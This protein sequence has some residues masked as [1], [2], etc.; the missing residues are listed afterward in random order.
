MTTYDSDLTDAAWATLQVVWPARSLRGNRPRW[1]R[2]LV[3]DAILEVLRGA[4]AWRALPKEVPPWRAVLSHVRLMRLSDVWERINAALRGQ[5][6]VRIGRTAEPQAAIIDR[7]S[8][9]TTNGGGARGVD[10]NT[11]IKGRNRH[12][13]VDPL[14]RLVEAVKA[15]FPT[16]NTIWADQGAAGRGFQHL[17]QCGT[18]A[19][20]GGDGS[21][22]AA[23]TFRAR[24]AQGPGVR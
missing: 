22:A 20:S 6:R 11:K 8:A 19:G 1:P 14:G 16:R 5:Y 12:S 3:I 9:N 10:G 18:P 2:R 13:L 15:N 17:G 23:R 4:I 24:G 7:Q 21:V